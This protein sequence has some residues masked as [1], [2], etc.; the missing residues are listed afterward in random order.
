MNKIEEVTCLKFQEK[1]KND[2]QELVMYNVVN[3]V[4][5]ITH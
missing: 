2:H 4:Y 5:V 3:E 1:S